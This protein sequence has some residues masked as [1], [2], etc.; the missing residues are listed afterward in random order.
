MC[1]A[2]HALITMQGFTVQQSVL[3]QALQ[4]L[5]KFCLLCNSSV[6]LFAVINFAGC[7]VSQPAANKAKSHQPISSAGHTDEQYLLA[8]NLRVPCLSLEQNVN[9]FIIF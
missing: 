5:H 6:G 1:P 8:C 3:Q 2:T 4:F 9:T 7:P